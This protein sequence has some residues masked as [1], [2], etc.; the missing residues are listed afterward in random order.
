[1][2][3]SLLNRHS[4][5]RNLFLLVF[6]MLTFSCSPANEQ[7]KVEAIG[8]LW[9]AKFP[10]I[11]E[12]DIKNTQQPKNIIFVLRNNNDY[13]FANIRFFA[14][15][16]QL[17]Q[18]KPLVQDTL[19]YI[20]AQPDG[21]WIGTGFGSTK[22]IQLEYKSNY[23]FPAPGKYLIKIKHAMRENVLNGIEDVGVKIEPVKKP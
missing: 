6:F 19:N 1:M 12:F 9:D 14:S 13:P 7:V 20:I 17:N 16:T 5:K 23:T 15:I 10:I 8:G 11:L 2:V 4:K 3:K 22:E 21:K 18:S